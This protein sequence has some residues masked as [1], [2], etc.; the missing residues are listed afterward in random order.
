MAAPTTPLPDDVVLTAERET[1]EWFLD[2]FR[3]VMLRKAEGLTD[4]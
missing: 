4:D 1:L 3:V 2:Y